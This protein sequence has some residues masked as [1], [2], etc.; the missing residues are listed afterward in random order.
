M[1]PSVQCQAGTASWARP[2]LEGQHGEGGRDYRQMKPG[3]GDDLITEES[4]ED[5]AR[6]WS[7]PPMSRDKL[8][9]AT[10]KR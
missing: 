8:L 6:G 7:A 4:E 2:R 3:A 1:V 10:Q 9:V 5:C